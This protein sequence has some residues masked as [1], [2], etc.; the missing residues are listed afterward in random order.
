M[1]GAIFFLFLILMVF[2]GIAWIGIRNTVL[3]QENSYEGSQQDI[4]SMCF[5]SG[6]EATRVIKNSATDYTVT[7]TRNGG[8][9]PLGGVKLVFTDSSGSQNYITDVSGNIAALMD[10][11][12]SVTIDNLANPYKV[13][14][15]A[16]F[17][18]AS[19]NP[20]L[21]STSNRFTFG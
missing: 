20:Q 15:V 5:E 11:T 13:D 17:L 2:V 4:D 3:E 16:Y 9:A 19:G 1:L 21:C 14:V 18:D 8:E 10:K 12:V 7:L 6:V